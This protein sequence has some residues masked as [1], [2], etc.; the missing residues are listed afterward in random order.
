MK[1]IP[2]LCATSTGI[3]V[4]ALGLVLARPDHDTRLDRQH[5]PPNNLAR[6]SDSH[7][8]SAYLHPLSVP[9]SLD[10]VTP[11]PRSNSRAPALV[12][13]TSDMTSTATCTV[14]TVDTYATPASF[15]PPFT[16]SARQA[17]R[18]ASNKPAT[19]RN[20]P[21]HARTVLKKRD[22]HTMPRG[23]PPSFRHGAEASPP[24]S[25]TFAPHQTP[26]WLKRFS[27]SSRDS[28]Q[29]STSR[30]DSS[31]I[32]VAPSA[33]GSTTP[34]IPSHT[35]PIN[36]APNKLVKR[37][38]SVSKVPTSASYGGSTTKIPV[39]TLR[40]P[41]TSHKRS[42]TLQERRTPV[43]P[44]AEEAFRHSFYDSPAESM[45]EDVQ[46]RNYFAPRQAVVPPESTRRRSST[47]IPNPIKKVY[48]DRKYRPVLVSARENIKAAPIEFDDD[49][50]DLE[51]VSDSNVVS[52]VPVADRFYSSSQQT[53]LASNRLSRATVDFQ[54]TSFDSRID[55]RKSIEDELDRQDIAEMSRIESAS[56]S[57][58][59]S[60]IL[61]A[62][63]QIWKQPPPIKAAPVAKY[64][65]PGARARSNT[66]TSMGNRQSLSHD[67]PSDAV[68]RQ[69]DLDDLTQTT[70]PPSVSSPITEIDLRLP[71]H[72]TQSA[73]GASLNHADPSNPQSDDSEYFDTL[74][75]PSRPIHHAAHHA[76]SASHL[77]GSDSEMRLGEDEMLDSQGDTIYD[78]VR[79]RAPKS[80]PGRRGPSIE[81]IFG[82]S[83]P[84]HIHGKHTMLRDYLQ[85]GPLHD[86]GY[87]LKPRHSIIHE[88]D[89]I[90]TPARSARQQSLGSSPML[91]MKQSPARTN[92]PSSP[93]TMPSLSDLRQHAEHFPD[94]TD[95]DDD[96]E[97]SWS[98]AEDGD[99][100]PQVPYKNRF[101]H[102]GIT[103]DLLSPH[104]HASSSA[105]TT[106]QRP[107]IR[108]TDRDTRS[109]IFDWSEQQP[110][111][112]SPNNRSPPRPKTVH[113]KKDAETRG[114]RSVGRRAPS[115]L[116]VRSQSVPVAQ[117]GDGKRTG[118]NKFGTWGIGSKG[119]TEDWNEDFDF[120]DENAP[121]EKRL[122]SGVS[123][124][125]PKSIRDQ[126][127][128]VLAN[129]GLLRDWG[130]LIEELKELKMRAV[131][132]EVLDGD[133]KKMWS[134]VDAMIDLADQESDEQTLA[135]RFS[136]S[137]SP[138]FNYDAF[139]DPLPAM[140]HLMPPPLFGLP[141]SPA[142]GEFDF[143]SEEATVSPSRTDNSIFI[144]PA[145]PGRPRK[146][147]EAI[148][149]SV[150]EALQ[151]KRLS[152]AGLNI[153]GRDKVHFDTATLK[154]IIPYVQELRDRVK[155]VIRDAEDLLPSPKSLGGS[156]GSH[157]SR[158]V[159]RR[160][161]EV[162]ESPTIHRR[163]RR[164]T[165]AIER[166]SSDDGLATPTEELNVRL[167]LMAMT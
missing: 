72:Q 129:I 24:I 52:N 27:F 101:A 99:D 112:K 104:G 77:A 136:P 163:S 130:L 19:A 58:S 143:Y 81:T 94:V 93:P 47:S 151:Q 78:S 125:V 2:T 23:T 165:S 75:S 15:C 124:F 153:E 146:N 14:Q 131:M 62:E 126:Q 91:H 74:P 57:F 79:T 59:V 116:H 28:T 61:P 49:A 162:S 140:D 85:T 122:D 96:E 82:D 105:N 127:T 115:G 35:P 141:E 54:S 40:R 6:R 9:S 102:L 95:A 159:R 121:E 103:P 73:L 133:N 13:P 156:I 16:F 88:E 114:S 8:S 157:G 10:P 132:L 41:A 21:D 150:I 7:R 22:G 30:P 109:S 80:S 65:R 118:T 46:W 123:M 142:D 50:D 139:D 20:A 26:S 38:T 108:S 110:I 68:A 98:F 106:P 107:T 84:F 135:P 43:V 34:M 119:V 32:S 64:R 83:P 29:S 160:K 166:T 5:R 70:K 76:D 33:S 92:F 134:E 69:R 164:S 25:P 120:E 3:G 18:S 117:E 154:R 39:P 145:T 11:R 67:E 44:K 138:S 51:A 148:A 137:S 128:N 71:S 42:A 56:S 149:R 152:N 158:S 4:S 36:T 155:K 90:S 86:Q 66:P 55:E 48:A 60:D 113:G 17:L 45:P 111:E 37:S 31:V 97:S 1:T 144:T 63:P 100:E 89:A 161:R 12:P 53:P 147:S 87:S 167:R